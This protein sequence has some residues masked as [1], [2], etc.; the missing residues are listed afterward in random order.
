VGSDVIRVLIVQAVWGA[1]AAVLIADAARRLTGWWIGLAA[2][3]VYALYGMNVFFDGLILM[4]SP[5]L[6]LEA[7]M[8]WLWTRTARR[9]GGAADFAAI[10]AVTGLVALGRATGALFL[11]A[12]WFLAKRRG[13]EPTWRP[14]TRRLAALVDPQ[15]GDR[16]RVHSLQLQLRHQPVRREQSRRDGALP[17]GGGTA[18][19]RHGE[20]TAPG[21]R[22]RVRRT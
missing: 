19:H 7:L 2:G 12:A 21:R 14:A 10:G 3:L 1:G 5:V 17:L 4:E 16:A 9:P 18:G 20:G 8:L 13:E 6:F 15:L 11:V 22:H